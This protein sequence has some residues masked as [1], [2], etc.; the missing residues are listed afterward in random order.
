MV[1]FDKIIGRLKGIGSSSELNCIGLTDEGLKLLAKNLIVE[2][3]DEPYLDFLYVAPEGAVPSTNNSARFWFVDSD[4]GTFSARKLINGAWREVFPY[5]YTRWVDGDSESFK[6]A[7]WAVADGRAK[8][9]PDLSHLFISTSETGYSKFII[10][11]EGYN[12]LE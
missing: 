8:S 3:P 12:I 7:G 2:I 10:A 4:R 9:V 1:K 11:F 6:E 5:G